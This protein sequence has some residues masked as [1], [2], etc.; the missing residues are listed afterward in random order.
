MS[1]HREGQFLSGRVLNFVLNFW[2]CVSGRIKVG[3]ENR[4][5]SNLSRGTFLADFNQVR[6]EKEKE[7]RKTHNQK[8]ERDEGLSKNFRV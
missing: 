2:A 5:F 7:M 8:G 4:V 6:I 3:E 1:I